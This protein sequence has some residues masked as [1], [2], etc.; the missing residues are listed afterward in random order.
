MGESTSTRAYA[1]NLG[2]RDS[3]CGLI[4]RQKADLEAH[5]Q[6]TMLKMSAMTMKGNSLLRCPRHYSLRQPKQP[7]PSHA[8]YQGLSA[9][10]VSKQLSRWFNRCTHDTLFISA[11]YFQWKEAHILSAENSSW[12]ILMLGAW[13]WNVWMKTKVQIFQCQH[14]LSQ[15]LKHLGGAHMQVSTE[16]MLS[17]RGLAARAIRNSMT[18]QASKTYRT[19]S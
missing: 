9:M 17:R 15:V 12:M 14:S 11:L 18:E 1:L 19:E 8:R 6:M 4:K 7:S 16:C 10:A 3:L 5:T 13:S 2:D